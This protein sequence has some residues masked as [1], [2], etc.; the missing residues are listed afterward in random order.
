MIVCAPAI[1]AVIVT[2]AIGAPKQAGASYLP[3]T[4]IRNA[5]RHPGWCRFRVDA[6]AHTALTAAT[7][8]DE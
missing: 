8:L 4:Q 1:T 3:W 2:L 7:A 5:S 6:K